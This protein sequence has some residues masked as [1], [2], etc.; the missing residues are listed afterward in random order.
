[1][2][3]WSEEAIQ[4]ERATWLEITGLP[5]HCWNHVT[6]KKMAELWGTLGENANH[7]KDSEK[8]TVLITTQNVKK[9]EELVEIEVGNV[10]HLVRVNETSFFDNSSYVIKEVMSSNP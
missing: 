7:I 10:I 6:I 8:V 1:M 4:V 3:P 5:L 9:I 2:M